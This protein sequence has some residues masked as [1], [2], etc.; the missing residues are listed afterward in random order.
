MM[1]LWDFL[2]SRC[3]KVEERISERN[4]LQKCS[5]G[6]VMTKVFSV[7]GYDRGYERRRFPMYDE[8]LDRNI[9]SSQHKKE[10][11]KEM[12]LVQIDGH[13]TRGGV[14]KEK[15]GVVYSIP[16]GR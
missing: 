14:K 4:E 12:N 15:Q 5:C 16:K 13:F 6:K 3:G 1:K 9:R 10:V 2:C 7:Q 11:L 8:S